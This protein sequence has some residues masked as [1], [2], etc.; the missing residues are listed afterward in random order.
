MIF[1]DKLL[2]GG[3]KGGKEA[4][5]LLWNSV[6]DYVHQNISNIPSDYK[7]VT[8]IYANLKGLGGVCQRSGIIDRQ[9]MIEDFA[10][11]F[12][13]SKQLFDFID[14]GMGKDRADDKISGEPTTCCGH[15]D[16]V[17]G[18]QKYSNYI[19]TTVIADI[20]FLAVRMIMAMPGFSK[21]WQIHQK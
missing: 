1:D 7:I 17:N 10:R 9:E 13:G 12:T 3:E 11:G 15:R 18:T 21:T 19:S 16:V 8:R 14:V 20:S 6:T 5:R 4:A 2:L